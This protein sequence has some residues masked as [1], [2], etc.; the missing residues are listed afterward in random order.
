MNKSISKLNLQGDLDLGEWKRERERERARK[1][2]FIPIE[3]ANCFV[4]SKVII[5][6]MRS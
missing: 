5:I 2:E 4:L 6:K 3:I 1:E